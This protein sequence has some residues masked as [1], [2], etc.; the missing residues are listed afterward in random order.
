MKVSGEQVVFLVSRGYF[1]CKNY[2]PACRAVN[3]FPRTDPAKKGK[4]TWI[5]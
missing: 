3:D 2:R 1:S 4:V 5:F